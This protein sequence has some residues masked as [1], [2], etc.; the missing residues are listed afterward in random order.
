LQILAQQCFPVQL[1]FKL[2]LLRRN[3]W[4]RMYQAV[5]EMLHEIW[6]GLN[7]VKELELSDALRLYR[8]AA[9]QVCRGGVK[10]LLAF[11]VFVAKPW[12]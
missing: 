12:L 4:H 5:H 11:V 3:D 7:W 1:L 8:L 9:L 6:I 10:L 2:L